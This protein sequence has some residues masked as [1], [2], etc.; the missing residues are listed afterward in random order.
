MDHPKIRL[1]IELGINKLKDGLRSAKRNVDDGVNGMK[2]KLNEVRLN[3]VADIAALRSNMREAQGV[4]SSGTG[5]IVRTLRNQF[6]AFA[7]FATIGAGIGYAINQGLEATVNK[8]AFETIVG[9]KAGNQLFSDLTKFAQD[10]IFGNELYDNAKTML[11]FGAAAKEVMPDL[12][13]LGDI[14]MGNK[15]KLASLTLAFSQIRS[16]GRLMG[17]DLLQL[18]NAGFNPLT[19]ISEKTGKSMAELK[20]AVEKGAISFEMVKQAFISATS[21]GGKFY[22]MTERIADT[23]YG[24]W[25]A[26]KGQL[27][28]IAMEFG[29]KLLPLMSKALDVITPLADHL[30]NLL[31]QFI[32]VITE[33]SSAFAAIVPEVAA[34]IKMLIFR[35]SPVMTSIAHVAGTILAPALRI[36]SRAVEVTLRLLQPLLDGIEIVLNA[37][38]WMIAKIFD[39]DTSK[40]IIAAY[41]TAGA[42]HG[43]AY[44]ESLNETIVKKVES[45]AKAL[46]DASTLKEV[47]D[48]G[49]LTG[50]EFAEGVKEKLDVFEYDLTSK[51]KLPYFDPNDLFMNK[52]VTF[53]YQVEDVTEQLARQKMEDIR[54]EDRLMKEQYGAWFNKNFDAMMKGAKPE[55]NS[56]KVGDLRLGTAEQPVAEKKKEIGKLRLA[57]IDQWQS[58]KKQGDDLVP[59]KVTAGGKS[60]GSFDWS[61]S[62]KALNAEK[63]T[64]SAHAAKTI[65]ITFGSYIKGDVITQNKQIQNMSPEELDRWLR[66]H[67]NRLIANADQNY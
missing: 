50:V 33:I 43:S 26:F 13:M 35:L 12:R 60:S 56:S 2:A 62:G 51:V 59:Q 3:R 47:K 67:F 39:L 53:T 4:V 40:S 36:V 24:K 7:S 54:R 8:T 19:I 30:P 5:N 14:S 17:Q 6:L 28:G 32:P 29:M 1:L 22:R 27:Q 49:K 23:P 55:V 57:S 64:G 21:E 42:S 46:A 58:Q 38:D 48:A 52:P 20:K 16:S 61:T 34:L 41:G 37:V 66:G 10:S 15:E 31:D 44:S 9:E 25:E 63:I 65:N 11:A 45:P 18:V